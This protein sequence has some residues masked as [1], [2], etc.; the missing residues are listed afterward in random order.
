MCLYTPVCVSVSDRRAV[1]VQL[2]LDLL[3][4]MLQSHAAD[5]STAYSFISSQL[6]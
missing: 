5:W 6:Q 1:R 4:D 2:M 3:L